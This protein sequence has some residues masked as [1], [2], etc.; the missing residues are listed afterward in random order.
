[1]YVCMLISA[2]PQHLR[3]KYGEFHLKYGKL[4]ASEKWNLLYKAL[5]SLTEAIFALTVFNSSYFIS[6]FQKEKHLTLVLLS[7]FRRLW[8]WN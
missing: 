7:K 5:G 3:N 6:Y 2:T 1:M 8:G 4:K